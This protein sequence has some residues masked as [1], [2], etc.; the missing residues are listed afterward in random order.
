MS[1]IRNRVTICRVSS[2]GPSLTLQ[3]A[4]RFSTSRQAPE[5]TVMFKKAV[6]DHPGPSAKPLQSTLFRS[7]GTQPPKPPPQSLGVKRKIEMANVGGSALGSLHNTVYF[8]ENDF[9]DDLDLDSEE[10]EPFIPPPKIVRPSNEQQVPS[11]SPT[12][13]DLDGIISK[14][15]PAPTT[16]FEDDNID[17]KYP[18]LPP[19]PEDDPAPSSSIQLPWSSSPPSHFQKPANTRTL[20]WLKNEEPTRAPPKDLYKKPA[21][22]ARPKPTAPWNKSASA[23]K[24]EQKELRRQTKKNQKADSVQHKPRPKMASLFLSDEQRHVLNVVVEKGKSIFFTGSAGTGKSVL[25]REIIKKLR[26]KYKR[27]PDRVAVTASTGLAACNIEGVT[28]H[29]FAGIGLGKEEVPELVKKVMLRNAP[30]SN[31]LVL[32]LYRSRETPRPGTVGCVRK[33]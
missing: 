15:A 16:T 5:E 32:T 19:M 22:P 21:T 3:T 1:R 29:S 18:E 7:N 20:P 24:E 25:M 30:H 14:P 4:C 28:L 27:E 9:D 12:I 26:D 10:P 2:Y 17:I 6:Q 11:Q 13:I 33:S 8:D 31:A 23:I